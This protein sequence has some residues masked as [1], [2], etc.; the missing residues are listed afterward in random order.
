MRDVDAI[1]NAVADGLVEQGAEAVAIVGSH[2]RGDA[3]PGSDLDLAVIGEG[4]HYRLEAHRGLLVSMGWATPAEQRRRLYEPHWL[5]THVP[6]WRDA[7][8]VVDAGGLAASVQREARAWSW[9]MVEDEC[10]RWAAASVA[11]LSEEACKLGSALEEHRLSVAAVQRS[12]LALQLARPV[13]LRRRLLY[14]TENRLWELV[15]AEVGP[16]WRDAQASA[17]GTAGDEL[18][19]GCRSALRLFEL[20][21]AE[22]RPLLDPR[23][24]AVVEL[25]LQA[26]AAL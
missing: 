3:G 7:R 14:S 5:G 4:P 21:V 6:G 8:I 16:E 20:A 22:V 24:S 10:D 1:A 2:A 12:L 17:L 13:A 15:A 23:E 9:T 25:A 26:I 19:V 18:A 11:G